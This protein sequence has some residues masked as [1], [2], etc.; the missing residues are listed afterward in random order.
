MEGLLADLETARDMEQLML[1]P[2]Y[3]IAIQGPEGYW[4]H[5]DPY[6]ENRAVFNPSWWGIDEA[7][8]LLQK[9]QS[10]LPGLAILRSD[11]PGLEAWLEAMHDHYRSIVERS[12]ELEASHFSLEDRIQKIWNTEANVERELWE[13]VLETQTHR[14]KWSH[15]GVVSTVL[16]LGAEGDYLG[17]RDSAERTEVISRKITQAFY[18]ISQNPNYAKRLRHN[19]LTVFH[20]YGREQLAEWLHDRCGSDYL[21]HPTLEFSTPEH[22]LALAV[23]S[24]LRVYSGVQMPG[25]RLLEHTSSQ[26]LWHEAVSFHPQEYL[27]NHD[28]PLVRRAESA[29]RAMPYHHPSVARKLRLLDEREE[30]HARTQET[31]P[32]G[33]GRTGADGPGDEPRQGQGTQPGPGRGRRRARLDSPTQ[34]PRL[35]HDRSQTTHG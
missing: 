26:M 19:L 10:V 16:A 34:G 35:R 2:H 21:P 13:M 7:Y 22:T 1:D 33:A 20:R 8:H 3:S 18:R 31:Q 28:H 32:P 12:R 25:Y 27:E 14:F 24:N 15:A 11:R 4:G 9:Y 17:A 5:L 30:V 6:L 23:L 29:V